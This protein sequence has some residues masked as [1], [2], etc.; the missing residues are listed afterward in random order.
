MTWRKVLSLDYIGLSPEDAAA[1]AILCGYRFFRL[2]GTIYV[3]IN[4]VAMGTSLPPREDAAPGTVMGWREVVD[5][6]SS[7]PVGWD[8]AQLVASIG[9]QFFT[10]GAD[11]YVVCQDAENPFGVSKLGPTSDYLDIMSL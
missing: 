2:Y 10:S 3:V 9:Y 5:F 11:L 7:P 4:G 1:K 6:G 8:P